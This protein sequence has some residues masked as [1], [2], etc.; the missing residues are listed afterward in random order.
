MHTSLDE[1]P[2]QNIKHMLMYT[3]IHMQPSNMLLAVTVD[4]LHDEYGAVQ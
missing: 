2:I 4:K 3:I 1:F